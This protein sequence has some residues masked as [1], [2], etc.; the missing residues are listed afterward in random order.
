MDSNLHIHE[1]PTFNDP[2]DMS[3]AELALVLY[4][5]GA[6]TILSDTFTGRFINKVILRASQLLSKRAELMELQQRAT[7]QAEDI[8][9]ELKRHQPITDPNIYF[10]YSQDIPISE[11]STGT[12]EEDWAQPTDLIDYLRDDT[13][14]SI[15]VRYGG[16]SNYPDW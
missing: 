5:I 8:R 2:N 16:D 11:W 14:E 15:D 12:L 7:K 13:N 9:E 1:P 10:S 6:K 4:H 3:S